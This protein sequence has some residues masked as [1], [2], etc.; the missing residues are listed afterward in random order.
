MRSIACLS[1]I[2][3]R[4]HYHLIEHDVMEIL[5]CQEFFFFLIYCVYIK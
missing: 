5:E 2:S 4:N 3:L 1:L